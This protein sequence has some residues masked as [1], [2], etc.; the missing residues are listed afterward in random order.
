MDELTRLEL[1]A[2]KN[3]LEAA[4][5]QPPPHDVPIPFND[6]GAHRVGKIISEA[7][8]APQAATQKPE[9]TE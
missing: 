2:L 1:E 3:V 7:A 8:T 4:A 9:P 6:K 5:R